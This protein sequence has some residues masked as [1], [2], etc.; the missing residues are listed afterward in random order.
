M[1]LYLLDDT[2]SVDVY[3][4]KCDQDYSDNI[5]VRLWESCPEEEKV[6]RAGVTNIF[7]TP[8]QATALANLL[9]AAVKNSCLDSNENR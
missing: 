3:Y 2:L 8:G 9:L 1:S 6:L 7:L 5:C 4:E